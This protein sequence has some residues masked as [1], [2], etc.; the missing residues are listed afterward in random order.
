MVK[1]LIV[2]GEVVKAKFAGIA[3]EALKHRI[4]ILVYAAIKAE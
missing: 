3:T 2:S 1:K 4:L